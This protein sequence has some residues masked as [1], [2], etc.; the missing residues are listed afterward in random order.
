MICLK[1]NVGKILRR[2]LIEENKKLQH[3]ST[4]GITNLKRLNDLDL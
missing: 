1:R 3:V 4:F 2:V